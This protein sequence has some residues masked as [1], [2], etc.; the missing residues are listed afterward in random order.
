MRGRVES[1]SILREAPVRG[2][3][4]RP[5]MKSA[6]ELTS[7]VLRLLVLYRHYEHTLQSMCISKESMAAHLF[8][9]LPGPGVVLLT[10][11]D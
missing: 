6:G 2:L 3:Q 7:E 5:I 9:T 11:Y 4:I 1:R 10:A 8:N